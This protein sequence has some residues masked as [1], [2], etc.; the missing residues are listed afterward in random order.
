LGPGRY[1]FTVIAC[2]IG[3]RCS[4]RPAHLTFEIPPTFLQTWMFKVA[5]AFLL[6]VIAWSAYRIWHRQITINIQRRT[7]ARLGERERIARD[8]HDTLLQGFQGLLLRIQ[9]VAN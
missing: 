4:V 6:A 5:M 8:L 9:G 7:E 3:A 1:E 2:E